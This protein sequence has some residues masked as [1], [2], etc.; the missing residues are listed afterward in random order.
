MTQEVTVQTSNFG[1]DVSHGPVIVNTISKSGGAD[2]H[3][4]GYI[5]A[6]NDALNANDWQSDHQ[7]LPKGDASYYYPGGNFGGPVPFTHK[8]VLGWFGYEHYLQN[9]G[10][11]NVL[12]S[13][14]PSSG[15][16]AEIS[17]RP[18][19]ATRLSARAASP[20]RQPTSATTCRALYLPTEL[21]SA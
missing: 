10:N 7:G 5:F 1:A 20:R 16:A 15:M 9:Q 19:R 6:R 11:A 3:G 14:I 8:K 21:R 18:E 4:E 2:Y 17:R 12:H 13:Y